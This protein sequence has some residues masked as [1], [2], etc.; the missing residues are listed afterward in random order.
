MYKN[1]RKAS[2]INKNDIYSDQMVA[3]RC[4][5]IMIM[6]ILMISS[7]KCSHQFLYLTGIKLKMNNVF[8]SGKNERLC[9]V[10]N[11][12]PIQRDYS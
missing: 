6:V 3:G 4:T 12:Q 1:E 11:F 8:I 5:Q 10:G 2:N 7:K 9:S